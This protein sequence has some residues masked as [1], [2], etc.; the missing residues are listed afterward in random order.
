MDGWKVLI[1]VINGKQASTQTHF[2]PNNRHFAL[3]RRTHC[4]TTTP[5]ATIQ[6]PEPPDLI[7]S[8]LGVHSQ[9]SVHQL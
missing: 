6:P 2:H 3:I 5:N 8:N 4:S 1:F 7:I 9:V